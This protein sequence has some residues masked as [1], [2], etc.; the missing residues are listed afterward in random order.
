MN[1]KPERTKVPMPPR[2]ASAV[3]HITR[4]FHETERL[5]GQ[6]TSFFC[7][8]E[9]HPIPL[10]DHFAMSL[11]NFKKLKESTG[12]AA[13]EQLSETIAQKTAPAFIKGYFC[14]YFWCAIKHA[15]DSYKEL[16]E[17]ARANQ[18]SLGENPDAWAISCIRE[19][20]KDSRFY[21]ESWLQSVCDNRTYRPS[22][23]KG[24]VLM[25]KAWRPPL[26]CLMSPFGRLPFKEKVAWER[27]NE[28]VGSKV[29]A[30]VADTYET[31]VLSRVEQVA[32]TEE[33][34]AL[35]NAD[36][37]KEPLAD[38]ASLGRSKQP[39]STKLHVGREVRR[40]KTLAMHRAWQKEYRKLQK[41]RPGMSDVWYSKKIAESAAGEDRGSETIRKQMKKS[42]AK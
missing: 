19:V 3:T 31:N 21:A 7:R 2:L 38:I 10:D 20:I 26:L 18:R 12:A 8:N 9:L 33:F 32:R 23:S 39:P 4:N 24:E 34:N 37:L 36:N 35:K 6:L 14:F 5:Y 41:R 13:T 16:L 42:W 17:V 25:V 15:V 11:S 1:R 40:N 29:M 30:F 27:T 22:A 28:K